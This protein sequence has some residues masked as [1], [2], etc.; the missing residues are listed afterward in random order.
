MWTAMSSGLLHD[1]GSLTEENNDE[2]GD[3]GFLA[4]ISNKPKNVFIFFFFKIWLLLLDCLFV[5]RVLNIDD[6]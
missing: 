2:E 1:G 5:N 4:K 6:E 3:G